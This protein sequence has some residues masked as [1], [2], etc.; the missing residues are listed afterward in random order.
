MKN[1]IIKIFAFLLLTSSIMSQTIDIDPDQKLIALKDNPGNSIV[2]QLTDNND[3]AEI[4][5]FNG[6]SNFPFLKVYSYPRPT[7]ELDYFDNNF[8]TLINN[9]GYY[10]KEYN[11]P[12]YEISKQNGFIARN[13]SGNI[14]IQ[15]DRDVNGDGRVSTNELEITGGSDLSENFKVV[16]EDNHLIPG[17]IVSIS[18]A[19]GALEITAKK[20]DKKVV[21]IVSGAN[22]IETGM[23]MGQKGSIADGD[24]PIALTGRAYVLVNTENGPIKAGDF[25]TS[26]SIP[27]TGMKVKNFKKAQGAIIGKAITRLE[28]D[29]GFVLILV[30]LQ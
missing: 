7:L 5:L 14:S 9:E 29:S 2:M 1:S 28:Q 20:R 27:G 22:G 25:I 8:S 6:E 18:E 10:L 16:D 19:H 24:I 26:S 13:E 21:G 17:M 15:I 12:I 30:N 23:T 11:V 3:D 4:K